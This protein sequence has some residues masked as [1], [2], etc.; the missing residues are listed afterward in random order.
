VDA[1]GPHPPP[2]WSR[3]TRRIRRLGA[4]AKGGHPHRGDGQEGQG[5]NLEHRSGEAEG[6]VK[7]IIAD[8]ADLAGPASAE[9]QRVITNA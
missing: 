9:V 3:P 4:A 8:L 7:R 6:E 1:Q 5:P 2:L